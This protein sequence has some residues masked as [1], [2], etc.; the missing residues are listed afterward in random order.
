LHGGYSKEETKL[1]WVLRYRS[2]VWRSI[3]WSRSY[4]TAQRV[5]WFNYE[6][7]AS[8]RR[9]HDDSTSCWIACENTPI[10]AR[11]G[12]YFRRPLIAKTSVDRPYWRF[13]RK[14]WGRVGSLDVSDP[15]SRLRRGF[16]AAS[17]GQRAE[18]R[19]NQKEGSQ[20]ILT[21]EMGTIRD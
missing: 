17:R 10:A 2:R 6:I 9:Q 4:R 21:D 7:V 16:G 15:R 12:P 8:V 20:Q 5:D 14:E 1:N 18:N 11:S 19:R 3:S 13:W